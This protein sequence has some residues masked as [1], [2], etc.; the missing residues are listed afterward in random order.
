MTSLNSTLGALH[1][2]FGLSTFL[3]GTVA[4]QLHFYLRHFPD[5]SKSLKTLVYLVWLAEL[6]HQLCV[7]HINW[8]LATNFANTRLSQGPQTFSIGFSVLFATLVS[9]TVQ[10]FFASRL[11]RVSKGT[12]VFCVLLGL[13]VIRFCLNLAIS[14]LDFRSPTMTNVKISKPLWSL[15]TSTWA[16]SIATD[17]LVTILLSYDLHKRRSGVH[18]TSQ[19]ID[20]LIIRIIATEMVTS[21][22]NILIMICF[23]TM[24][25][26][27]WIAI[28]MIQPHLFSNAM[29][30]SLNSRRVHCRPMDAKDSYN[31]MPR[32]RLTS[33]H[34]S[35]CRRRL[36]LEQSMDRQTNNSVFFCYGND[37]L[38]RECGRWFVPVAHKRGVRAACG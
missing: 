32:F 15:T 31:T 5:D 24:D 17:L 8:L 23:L 3:F 2:G 18:R 34:T 1:I 25:N 19:I 21:M 29:L 35:N 37:L 33:V 9:V 38:G 20:R 7:C 10:V 27:I 6:G 16:I 30:A 22:S 36:Y 4:V 12:T 13:I 28:F 11:W 14:V 26:F